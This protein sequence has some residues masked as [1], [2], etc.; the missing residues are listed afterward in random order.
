[1]AKRLELVGL[2]AVGRWASW[3]GRPLAGSAGE[4]AR[5]FLP[6]L[7]SCLDTSDEGG[8]PDLR[9]WPLGP[10]RGQQSRR[11]VDSQGGHCHTRR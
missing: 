3:G 10:S 1:M 7:A 6:L 9:V 4:P 8:S 2:R 5:G 11:P